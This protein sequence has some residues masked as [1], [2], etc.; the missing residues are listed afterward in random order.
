MPI[1][2]KPRNEP[3]KV[4][5]RWQRRQM[6]QME[7]TIGALRLACADKETVIAG[8]DVQLSEADDQIRSLQRRNADQAAELGFAR[9]SIRL[10]AERLAY[11]EGY[12]YAKETT[13]AARPISATVAPFPG[14]T[15]QTY[16]G[17]RARNPQDLQNGHEAAESPG[18]RHRPA[19]YSPAAGDQVRGFD[20][21]HPRYPEKS[22]VEHIEITED[23][24]K[25][26][27]RDNLATWAR[28]RGI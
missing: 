24:I 9:E 23:S 4:T 8:F 2:R 1:P 10:K 28:E 19:R 5:I 25:Q 3:P 18:D 6:I 21:D 26:S 13:P 7:Q 12:F 16:A 20:R 14:H 15:S 27:L 17:E 11:L 22:A